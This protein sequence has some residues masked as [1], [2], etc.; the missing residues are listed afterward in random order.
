MIIFVFLASIVG[1][2]VNM[3]G[4]HVENTADTLSAIRYNGELH[5]TT[6]AIFFAVNLFHRYTYSGEARLGAVKINYTQHINRQ[7]RERP[8]GNS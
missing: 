6:E 2:S 4:G 8:S 1:T 7:R 5:F 3:T